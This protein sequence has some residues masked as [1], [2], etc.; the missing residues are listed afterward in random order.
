MS[1]PYAGNFIAKS[2]A[3]L[4]TIWAALARAC[5]ERSE[6]LGSGTVNFWEHAYPT[7]AQIAPYPLHGA[8][9]G[10]QLQSLMDRT[11][12]LLTGACWVT[13]PGDSACISQADIEAAAGYSWDMPSSIFTASYL[14]LLK[15]AFDMMIRTRVSLGQTHIPYSRY[16]D[17]NWEDVPPPVDM[18]DAWDTCVLEMQSAELEGSSSQGFPFRIGY[19]GE[20]AQGNYGGNPDARCSFLS[21][22]KIVSWI[23]A[24]GAPLTLLR[25]SGDVLDIIGIPDVSAC[26]YNGSSIDTS[27]VH[28]FVLEFVELPTN[29][30]LSLTYGYS[31]PSYDDT[32]P[33]GPYFT[34]RVYVELNSA[35]GWFD[36]TTLLTDQA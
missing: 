31:F 9:H 33:T 11:L 6:I 27:Y 20:A 7:A 3:Q 2:G 23:G 10:E 34:E 15:T 25:I 26:T 29:E 12:Q 1:W 30:F 13:S 22:Q 16:G 17:Y 14:I 36:L 4:P 5:N 32:G 19:F 35:V 28:S 18:Y 24:H 21:R 8:Y